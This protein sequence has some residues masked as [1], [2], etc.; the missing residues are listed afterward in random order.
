MTVYE[1]ALNL[2][3]HGISFIPVAANDKTPAFE[4]LENKSWMEYKKRIPTLDETERWFKDS[5][6][7]IAIVGGQ[8][9]GNLEI[10]D[11]DNHKGNAAETLKEFAQLI[12]NHD[13]NI[14]KFPCETSQSGGFHLFYRCSSEVD[15]NKKLA[16]Q[17]LDDS[18]IDTFIETR[19]EGGYVI[20]APSQ[21][22]K[23]ING[24][25]GSIPI[26][27]TEERE[28]LLAAAKSFNQIEELKQQYIPAVPI[29]DDGS[30]ERPGDDF[31][32]KGTDDVKNMLIDAGWH[33]VSEQSNGR[34]L[35]RRPGKNRGISATYNS[36]P[37]KFYVFTSNAYPFEAERSYDNFAIYSLLNTNGDFKDAAKDLAA[38]GFGKKSRNGHG[39][40]QNEKSKTFVKEG[41]VLV[42][43]IDVGLDEASIFWDEVY[44]AK[45]FPKLTINKSKLINFLESNGFYKYFLDKNLSIFIRI[46][47]NVVT[48]ETPETIFDFVKEQIFKLPEHISSNFT[49]KD[50]W[51]IILQKISVLRSSDFLQTLSLKQVDFIRDTKDESYFY[52]LNNY[53]R[54]TL[55]KVEVKD[56]KD[57]H[58]FIW[59]DQVIKYNINLLKEEEASDTSKCLFGRFLEKVCSPDSADANGDKKK[60]KV[61]EQRLSALVSAL[62][63]LL[64]TYQDPAVPKAV[65]FCEEKIARDDE[66]NGRTG[67]GLTA[68]ALKL[69]RKRVLYNGKQV[70]FRDRFIFQKITPDTQL[71]VFDDVKKNFD[72][73]FLFSVL[74]EG[75]T[76]EKK[77]QKPIDIP[78]SNTPKILIS[79]NSVLSNDTDSHKA[80]KFE[81]EYSDYFSADWTP[82]D[83]FKVN[84][85]ESGWDEKDVEWDRFF[86]FMIYSVYHYLNNGLVEYQQINLEERKLLAKVP[87]EFVEICYEEHDK[88]LNGGKVFKEEIYE[89]FIKRNKIYGPNG[90]YAV[91]QR[92]TTRWFTY[93]LN[94]KKV[95]FSEHKNTTRDDRR[96]YWKLQDEE[97]F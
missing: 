47:K 86:S 13:I 95:N 5:K 55:D 11:F 12:G 16:K 26:I 17:Y 7:S 39:K 2:L 25:F 51:E 79:T 97:L 78:F 61:D 85:F 41:G 46:K 82:F 3:E 49:N 29:Y 73:E 48:D 18:K 88:I 77:G 33:L 59:E 57:L 62:G 89:E 44:V 70:D 53:V 35:W 40:P 80:R 93:F 20:I 69:M 90:K 72:F 36:I 34:Q 56:Y 43:D 68:S 58:Y 74:T 6:N 63:Y 76:I 81:I 9:S 1:Q 38:K 42:T 87:E 22:Y 91:T 60:R 50:L 83:E 45:G 54:V 71:I 23:F 96:K 37:N 52:F 27:E 67:K 30:E 21:G 24:S 15:G 84:F 8:V 64:H 65:V 4:Y 75:I 66:S 14:R 31:N 32:L 10:I 94:Y 19:A 92:T 28:F